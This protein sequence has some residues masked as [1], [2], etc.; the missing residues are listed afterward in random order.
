MVKVLTQKLPLPQHLWT[1][2]CI[3]LSSENNTFV[4]ISPI[5][6]YSFGFYSFRYYIFFL[7]LNFLLLHSIIVLQTLS[8][9]RTKTNSQ[10]V[11]L[12]KLNFETV[13]VRDPCTLI[14]FNL[15]RRSGGSD[16]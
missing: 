13:S 5:I 9:L 2:V 3:G 11:F 14:S 12:I 15:G 6:I 4:E 16:T 7:R 8:Q 10:L 1:G